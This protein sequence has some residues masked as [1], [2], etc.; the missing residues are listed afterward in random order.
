MPPAVAFILDEECRSEALKGELFKLSGDLAIFL[1]RR[2]YENYLLNPAAIA[3][4]AN[5]IEGFRANAVTPE[6]VRAVIDAKL[7][8]AA[9]FCAADKMKTPANRIRYVDAAKV[10]EELFS[11]LSQTRVTYQKVP[12]G[13]ALTEW[14]IRNAPRD[15]D[16]IVALLS[17]VLKAGQAGGSA[18]TDRMMPSTG[19]APAQTQAG[20]ASAGGK[21]P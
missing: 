7:G 5:S 13:V 19:W 2:M 14:L 20:T 6:E 11:D 18:A 21:H 9:Y 15:L 12:H 17:R 1:P 8:N 4:V 10:L 16:E 3:E